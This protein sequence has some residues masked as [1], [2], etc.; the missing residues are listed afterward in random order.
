[1]ALIAVALSIPLGIYDFTLL[2]VVAFV[3]GSGAGMSALALRRPKEQRVPPLVMTVDD[4]QVVFKRAGQV[5]DRVERRQVALAVIRQ[6]RIMEGI[7]LYDHG[8]RLLGYWTINRF[9]A[10]SHWWVRPFRRHGWPWMIDY[11]VLYFIPGRG[12]SHDAPPWAKQL[13]RR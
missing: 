8:C 6:G 4:T 3:V 2:V 10:W 1:M 13:R 11:P 9:Y 12:L 5:V 7:R